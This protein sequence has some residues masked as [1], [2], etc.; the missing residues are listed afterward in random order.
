MQAELSLPIWQQLFD[1][2]SAAVCLQ[3]GDLCF[4]NLMESGH[5]PVQHCLI[6][7]AQLDYDLNKNS[8][9][10]NLCV[11]FSLTFLFLALLISVTQASKFSSSVYLQLYPNRKV[12]LISG[13]F[14][15]CV[16]TLGNHFFQNKDTKG[17]KVVISH[18][19]GF[20]FFCGEVKNICI[21]TSVKFLSYIHSLY[22]L[23]GLYLLAHIDAELLFLRGEG[24]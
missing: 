20:L 5:L 19:S 2:S 16:C 4:D 12:K 21:T 11:I 15:C 24:E 6:W 18:F 1:F 10:Q 9:R 22:V 8:R 14:M 13:K 23:L 3:E 17:K 7:F